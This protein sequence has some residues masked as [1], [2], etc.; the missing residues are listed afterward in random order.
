ME[1]ATLLSNI[2]FLFTI[3]GNIVCLLIANSYGRKKVLGT[4]FLFLGILYS[5]FSISYISEDAFW[6]R[7]V[8]LMLASFVI[9]VGPLPFLW[10]VL[11][12]YLPV[13]AMSIALLPFNVI[14]FLVGVLYP[15]GAASIGISGCFW[16]IAFFQFL[17]WVIFDRIFIES[18]GKS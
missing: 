4:S 17:S 18:R 3:I 6:F 5:L 7:V 16:V 8:I 1:S 13:K 11:A 9:G 14:I 10:L 2:L 12:D 15:I